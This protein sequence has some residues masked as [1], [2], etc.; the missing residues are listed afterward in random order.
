MPGV[1]EPGEMASAR[2]Y[3][4]GAVRGEV[5]GSVTSL[6]G[7]QP[8]ALLVYLAL[9]RGRPVPA[10]ELAEVLWPAGRAPHWEGA[11]R[12]VVAKV[13]SFLAAA[14]PPD[15]GATG[16]GGPVIGNA[17]RTYRF[18]C[19]GHVVVDVWRAAAAVAEAEQ[20]LDTRPA[21]A[22][23]AAAEAIELLGPG[24]LP[25]VDAGWLDPWRAGLANDL[26]RAQRVASAAHRAR[27]EHDDALAW[28]VEA[29][30]ADRFDEES[31]RSLMAAHFAA[32]NRGAALRAY[33]EG[34]RVLAD[35]LGAS[36]SA[37]TEALHLELLSAG[38]AA[39]TALPRDR[40]V[41][42]TLADRHFVGRD[43][44]LAVLGSA[45]ELARAG[46]R[47]VVLMHGEAGVGKSRL[48]LE[49][50]RRLEPVHVLY[51]RSS[52]EQI[53][54]FEPF[55]E[56]I[57]RHLS[58]VD[59]AELV[60]LVGP[61]GRELGALVPPVAARYGLV[62]PDPH[63]GDPEGGDG[64]PRTFEAVRSILTRIATEPTIL[65]LDD[66]HWAD[67]STLLLCRHLLRTLDGTRLLAVVTYRDDQGPVP[68][69]AA[70]VT[71][72]HRLEGFQAVRIPGL[73]TGPVAELLRVHGVP[74]AEQLGPILHHQTGGNCFYLTQVLAATAEN[75]DTFDPLAIP[76]TVTELVRQRLATLTP[77]A[78][79]VLATAAVLGAALS[80]E[81]LERAI[82]LDG[83][84]VEGLDEL[85]DRALLF[86]SD[87][88][89]LNFAHAIVRDAVVSG[90]PRSR[91][92]R[93][94][95]LAARSIEE[96]RS[97][98]PGWEAAAA[99]HHIAA[100]DPADAVAAL[101]AVVRAAGHALRSLAYDQAAD[102]YGWA[103][104]AIGRYALD[105]PRA[106]GIHVGLG[107]ARRRA[108]DFAAARDALHAA[109]E[110]A[111]AP[112]QETVFADAALELVARGGRGVDVDLSDTARAAL[113][114][115][116]IGR[117]G[118]REP[119]LLVSLLSELALALLLTDEGARR[120]EAAERAVRIAEDSGQTELLARA[121]LADRLLMTRPDRAP[122]RLMRTE[123]FVGLP[124]P[125]IGAEQLV[126]MHMWRITDCFELG[127][128]AGVDRELMALVDVAAEIGQP[129]WVWLASTWQALCTFVDGDPATAEE[130][131]AAAL[132]RVADLGHPETTLAYGIQLV[133][134]R[135]QQDRGS[136]VVD[137]LEGVVATT[138]QVPAVRCGLAFALAQSGRTDEARE[139]LDQLMPG[140]TARVP[141]DGNWSVAMACLAETACR[142]GDTRRAAAILPQLEPLRD[143][144]V[145]ATGFGAGGA[146][147]G[148]FSVVLASIRRCLGD[149]P[150]AQRDL[151]HAAAALDRF[152]A[153]QMRDRVVRLRDR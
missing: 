11:L 121:V 53:V 58:K 130:L 41:L 128:R 119:A 114:E 127:D 78:R 16:A 124:R 2:L 43:D 108:G 153:P 14:L 61:H 125:E 46:A 122:E 37:A 54:P 1:G 51:G 4:A 33:G 105:D 48:A 109:L 129:Y 123:R 92:R 140:T 97:H 36:P 96:S 90:L 82:A 126:R 138:P 148:P 70:A 134:F 56:A 24:L 66:L 93:L 139:E 120:R 64:R 104:S 87:D 86:E 15:A 91:R 29:V 94:H 133:G 26:R 145:V 131:A 39:S 79:R 76:G 110:L 5:G 73:G 38:E 147:W 135:L 69:F 23:R 21:D 3:L 28:A 102:L 9:Q 67:P 65:V 136:E 142:L 35:E 132:E 40:H 27:G 89:D 144:F 112:G 17:G 20:V 80:P 84:A 55:A 10:D 22:V 116:A 71:E 85:L 111:R 18:E 49:A 30:A 113:L 81:L 19:P 77:E 137:L 31:L 32:G 118:D 25:G 141:D 107:A 44:E 88:G 103:S 95:L 106:A 57:E 47:Q 34:R 62:P 152:G 143:R 100:D 13:R 146:C 151:D 98:E 68:D 45:W 74:S 72:L 115:E 83:T 12:G 63:A 101:D 150:G 7:A 99:H 52:A 149:E 117:L 8:R 75:P 42:P 50:V 59:D 60:D 6:A